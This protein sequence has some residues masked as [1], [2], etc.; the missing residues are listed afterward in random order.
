MEAE[1]EKKRIRSVY[2]QRD[3][4]GKPKLYSWYQP[5]VLLNKYRFQVIA[6]SMLTEN[7]INNLKD[8]KV[9]DI[10][11]GYGNWLRMLLEWGAKLENLHGVDLLVDRIKL[12][13][14]LNPG[15]D[16]QIASGFSLPFIDS[17]IDLVSVN[18]VFSSILNPKFRMSFANEMKRVLKSDGII[19]IY[20]FRISHPKNPNTVSLRKS[21]I[22]RLFPFY[23]IK[24]RSLILAPPIARVIAP[25]SYL[26]AELIEC[27]FPFLRT[28]TIYLI[29]KNNTIKT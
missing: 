23:N 3:A 5:D 25:I 29:K 9:L 7:R 24:S 1:I 12:A 2:A 6:S 27:F 16:Y 26:I 18:T 15:I 11:C 8:I 10:G 21:E 17:C 19:M 14:K 13:R 20:D 28:H 22:Q 4:G